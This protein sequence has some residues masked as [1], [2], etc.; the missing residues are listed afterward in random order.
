VRRRPGRRAVNDAQAGTLSRARLAAAAIVFGRLFRERWSEEK[1]IGI[2]LPPSVASTA[3]NVASAIAGKPSVNLNYTAGRA[4]LESAAKQAEL[5]RVIT[6]RA[7]LEKGKIE[8]P[9]GVEIVYLEDERQKIGKLDKL[10]ALL[11]A[12]YASV[13]SIERSCGA[14]RAPRLD[15]VVTIIFSSGSTGEPKGVPLT[16]VNL[17]SNAAGVAQVFSS[18]VD[19]GLLGILPTFHSFGYLAMWFALNHGVFLACHANPLDAAAV[20]EIV[21]KHKLT[22][23]ICTPTLLGIYLRRW[24]RR[25]RNASDCARSRDTARPNARRWSR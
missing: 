15:D 4:G 12:K 17:A 7:F 20:G 24:R 14:T 23:M 22:L 5:K 25:S 8:A 6:S 9:A 2:L 3:L 13:E 11:A 18:D 21:E 19:E 16:H 1:A 10:R